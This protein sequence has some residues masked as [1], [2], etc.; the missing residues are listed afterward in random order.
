MSEVASGDEMSHWVVLVRKNTPASAPV[1]AHYAGFP[2]SL[3]IDST[4]RSLPSPDFLVIE[5]TKEGF[6]LIRYTRSGEF[7]GD[8][9]HQS[10][11]D[12]KDQATYEFRDSLTEWREVPLDV[13]DLV[14]YVS[15]LL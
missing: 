12:A 3:A 7:G 6:Y 5:E 8:T 2:K 1:V 10:L 15:G 13:E 9:W 11:E 14:S 4:P